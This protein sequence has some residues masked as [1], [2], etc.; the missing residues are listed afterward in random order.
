M[1][2]YEHLITRRPSDEFR[3]LVYFC[4]ESGE[5]SLEEVGQDQAREI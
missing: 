3:N 2:R 1:T 5:C 4:S